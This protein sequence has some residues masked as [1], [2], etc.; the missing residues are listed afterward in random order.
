[1]SG[2]FEPFEDLTEDLQEEISGERAD[3]AVARAKIAALESELAHA[4]LRAEAEK[5][6][7]MRIEAALERQVA[8]LMEERRTRIWAQQER[9]AAIK[10]LED[11]TSY[12]C[13]KSL[14]LEDQQ[15]GQGAAAN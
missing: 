8:N 10:R 15:R 9:D 11:V 4:E 14:Q 2:N 6:A 5:A 3:L 1:M 7:R 12:A 13:R